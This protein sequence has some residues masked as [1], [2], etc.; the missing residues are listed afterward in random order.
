VPIVIAVIIIA[1]VL[2]LAWRPARSAKGDSLPEDEAH[3]LRQCFHDKA[4]MERLILAQLT[5]F[6]RESR[7]QAIRRAVEQGMR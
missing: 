6:P 3:L 2:W 4:R 1:L 5:K 7:A